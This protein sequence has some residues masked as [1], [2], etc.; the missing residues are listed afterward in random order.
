MFTVFATFCCI[1]FDQ[2]CYGWHIL[3]SGATYS[4]RSQWHET[5]LLS[6]QSEGNANFL[7]FKQVQVKIGTPW[8]PWKV[9]DDLQGVTVVFFSAV[10]TRKNYIPFFGKSFLLFFFGVCL[11][12]PCFLCTKVTKAKRFFSRAWAVFWLTSPHPPGPET[13]GSLAV[14]VAP[15][16]ESML[17]AIWLQLGI[18]C[19]FPGR[20]CPSAKIET[21]MERSIICVDHVRMRN[22]GFLISML[23]DWRDRSCNIYEPHRMSPPKCVGSLVTATAGFVFMCISYLSRLDRL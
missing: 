10:K 12:F 9:V 23:V 17:I 8:W 18:R 6:S 7:G 15:K 19:L 14:A 3:G 22:H 11:V 1:Y 16:Q 13:H 2:S 5:A 20:K 4:P 21:V